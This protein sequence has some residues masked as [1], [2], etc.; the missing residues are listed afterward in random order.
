[1]FLELLAWFALPI[2]LSL[3]LTPAVIKVAVAIGAMDQPNARKA[4]SS[5][6]P[7]LGGLGVFI[8]F[9]LGLAAVLAFS[10]PIL[11]DSWLNSPQGWALG[12]C[13]LVMLITGSIDDMKPLGPGKKFAVQFLCAIVL[14]AAGFTISGVTDPFSRGML[15]LGFFD[16]VVTVFWI[17]GVTNA[18]N[19]V[20]G[21]DGLAS[22]ISLFALITIC[23]ISLINGDFATATLVL[24]LAGAVLGFLNYNFNPARI[25][26]G[27]SGSLVLGIFL[28]A[29][30]IE[31]STKSSTV[32]AI[33]VPFL[34]LGLPIMD[35]LLSMTRRL[36]GSLSDVKKESLASRI[37]KMFVPDSNHIHHRLIAKGFSHKKAVL[38]LYAVS[39]LL[40]IG[41]FLITVVN[42][43]EA[44]IIL[45]SLGVLAVVGIRQLRYK[46]ISVF[47][48]GLLIPLY[49]QPI[50]NREFFQVLLDFVFVGISFSA[51][52]ALMFGIEG[53]LPLRSFVALTMLIAAVQCSVLWLTGVYKRSFQRVGVSDALKVTKS[54]VFAVL[55]AAVTLYFFSGFQAYVTVALF[56]LD[57]YFLLTLVLGSRL[58]IKVLRHLSHI[59]QHGGGKKTVIYGA[60]NLGELALQQIHSHA[61]PG[62]QAVGFLDDD[63]NLEGKFAHGYQVLGGHWKLPRLISRDGIEQVIIACDSVK[64]EI[65][66]RLRD[67][68]REFGIQ[69]R[70]LDIQLSETHLTT[71]RTTSHPVPEESDA[72]SSRPNYHS[73]RATESVRW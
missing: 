54:V 35:T 68:S 4:H 63:S 1:M 18:I 26:M 24:V 27:D 31:T 14:Y 30:S 15:D 42:Q 36:L 39:S 72:P 58:S 21:L 29:V 43:A 7:R 10:F 55:S 17:V 67:M 51:A 16:F 56:I 3:L 40:G 33:V 25:F 59:E 32:F 44:S 50:L 64:P 47:K 70:R 45:L 57:F 20:D 60:G 71:T 52:F 13:M 8:S 53:T 19:L 46:E 48:N 28:A 73:Q 2:A 69:V 9:C 22:G 66:R 38:I 65:L 23:L 37:K 12:T 11:G 62:L 34:A 6:I 61:I 5:P 41:A 49:S